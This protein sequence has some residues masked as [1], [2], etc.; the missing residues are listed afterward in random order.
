MFESCFATVIIPVYNSRPGLEKCLAS[1][2]AQTYPRDRFETI[3]VDDGSTD[4]LGEWV[5]AFRKGSSMDIKY[6][7]QVNKG[8]AAAR[9]LGIT[10]SR[11]D[12]I[13]FID[14][15]CIPEKNWLE[16]ILKGYDLDKTAGVGGIIEARSGDT[17]VSRYCAYTRMNRAPKVDQQGVVY[18]ITGNASFRRDRL[19]AAGGFDERFDF[20]GGED[21][22]LCYRLKQSGYI[23]QSNHNAVV[24]NR[25]KQYLS[26]LLRTYFNYGKGQA[27]LLARKMSR[28]DLASVSGAQWWFYFCAVLVKMS[29]K[30]I[31]NLKWLLRSIKIPFYALSYYGKGLSAGDGL[32][33]AAYDYLRLLV[34]VQ[35]CFCGYFIGKFRGFKRA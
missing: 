3:I 2:S 27:F 7:Y 15:D 23:F 5:E 18:L 13:A 16:E 8:P 12:I 10:H 1:L 17:P 21:P 28:R 29:L 25:H 9:N 30:F 31:V 32:R 4:G 11:G 33:Y 6:F 20:P 14:S 19:A 26:Q 34:F 35:G 24:Y 22:D